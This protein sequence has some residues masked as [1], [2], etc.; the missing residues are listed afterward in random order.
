MKYC[1]LTVLLVILVTTKGSAGIR[2]GYAKGVPRLKVS[3]TRLEEML[4]NPTLSASDRRRIRASMQSVIDYM[5]CYEVTEN[6]L[7]Q[8]RAIAPDLYLEIENLR[9]G[10]GRVVDVYVKLIR[11]RETQFL[12]AGTT[13][14]TQSDDDPQRCRSEYGEG[15]VSVKIWIVGH[16][17]RVLSHEFG[18]LAYMIPH[19]DSY[20]DFYKRRYRKLTFDGTFGHG[21]GDPSG[22]SAYVFE[23]RFRESHTRFRKECGESVRSPIAL[24]NPARRKYTRKTESDYGRVEPAPGDSLMDYPAFSFT[25][26]TIPL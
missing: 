26:G 20:V 22:A 25:P 8:F 6:I 4:R 19:L 23:H 7:R 11:T 10:R 2:N 5:V 14:F 17:L 24:V 21:P 16:S 15:T 13:V 12:A 1:F 9:D 18:H 3:L